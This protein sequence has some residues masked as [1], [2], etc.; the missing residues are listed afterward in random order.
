M[1]R[2]ARDWPGEPWS[3]R[4][5]RSSSNGATRQPRSRRSASDPTCPRRRCTGSSPRSSASSRPCSTRRSPVTISRVAVHERSDVASLLTEPDP[6]K[7][8]AGL[9]AVTTAINQR[10]N[11][12]YRVLASAAAFGPRGGGAP[13][14]DPA[15]ARSRSRP[16]RT[17]TCPRPRTQARCART[18]RRR[19]DP[20]AD[21]ARGLRATGDRPRLDV[22]ALPAMAGD[23][24]HPAADVTSVGLPAGRFG[25][26]RRSRADR[27]DLRR[28]RRSR[29][30]DHRLRLWDRSC[31][32][33]PATGSHS[34]TCASATATARSCAT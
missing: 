5:G 16:G 10:T 1:V 29:D 19:P 27:A 25:V 13:R 11:D 12:V 28:D 30:R 34:P 7:L 22:R 9:A 20:R 4:R 21:V 15:T 14:G 26:L 23:H 18:R 24:T 17:L 6:R 2:P 33:R 3:T 32:T 31:R 8:L